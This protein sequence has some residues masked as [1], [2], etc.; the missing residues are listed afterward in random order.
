MQ[1]LFSR[2]LSQKRLN[3]MAQETRQVILRFP[4]FTAAEADLAVPSATNGDTT[5]ASS[6]GT[7]PLGN[8]PGASELGRIVGCVPQACQL[9]TE[10]V[11]EPLSFRFGLK[12]ATHSFSTVLRWPIMLSAMRGLPP[13]GDISFKSALG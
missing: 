6:D 3:S 5:L 10:C 7:W 13:E 2:F 12:H 11:S 4:L 8:G 1:K 9:S